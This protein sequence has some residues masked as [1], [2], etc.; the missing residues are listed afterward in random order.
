MKN[1]LRILDKIV[2]WLTL[3]LVLLFILGLLWDTIESF[4]NPEKYRYV[5]YQEDWMKEGFWLYVLRNVGIMLIS[6]IF[7]ISALKKLRSRSVV[8][9]RLYYALWILI[10]IAMTYNLVIKGD[11]F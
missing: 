11:Q 7:W 6:I 9:S 2:N 10:L 8:W 4:T 3:F 1:L 5:Q